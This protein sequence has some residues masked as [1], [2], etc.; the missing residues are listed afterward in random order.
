MKKIILII[1]LCCTTPLLYAQTDVIMQQVKTYIS[2][3]DYKTA[4]AFLEREAKKKNV[5]PETFELLGD[6]Y[7]ALNDRKK[8]AQYYERRIA[9]GGNNIPPDVFL[10]YGELLIHEGKYA[11]AKTHLRTY[12]NNA[13]DPDPLAETLMASCDTAMIWV[14]R[15]D[16]NKIF[17]VENLKRLNSKFHDWG[18]MYHDNGIMFI[19]DRPRSKVDD[20]QYYAVY[21]SNYRR[22]KNLG[23]PELFFTNMKKNIHLGP[24]AF[25]KNGKTIYY[26]QTNT[27][28]PY[29]DKTEDGT[30]WE[31]KLEIKIAKITTNKLSSIKSFKYNS[32]REYSI[33]H[34]C[35]SP[36]DSV[37]Y[38]VSDMPG[39]FGGTDIYYSVLERG[40]EWSA[41]INAGSMIN[42]TGNEMFPTMDSTGVLYFSSNGKAG[43]GGLDIF[44]AKG[45]KNRWV[46]TENM[47][48]PINSSGDDFYL[49]LSSDKSSGFFASNRPGGA[50]NDDI[51]TLTV[52]G[53]FPDFGYMKDPLAY[54]KKVR[55]SEEKARLERIATFTG[56]VT[57]GATHEGIDSVM[58]SF[59]NNA[60][61][62]QVICTTGNA[63]VFSITLDKKGNYTYSCIREGYVPTIGQS[64]AG[65]NALIQ[66]K[67]IHIEMT[68]VKIEEENVIADNVILDTEQG[69]GIEYRVQVMASKEYPNWDYLNKVKEAYPQ[70]KILYG[71]FPDAFTR[72]TVGQFKTAKE[73]TKLKNELRAIGYRDAF[74]VMFVNGKRKVVSYN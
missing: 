10:H 62:E 48:Y 55:L 65:N 23:A 41:P 45:G 43:L 57:D 73:A 28:I 40:D 33:G 64:L 52:N 66:A 71:S 67:G 31:N 36:N 14:A 24:V 74:V 2:N 68:P 16:S 3:F 5:R 50:G 20:D 72:F 60:T 29:R 19:S 44:R 58:I 15:R 27:D 61:K 7:R 12:Y 13:A 38:Y 69:K 63:G 18:A 53:P 46:A 59:V 32:P 1:I 39:G 25:T 49:I 42:T 11:A 17:T 51:Y 21:Q 47:Y 6:C 22:D 30:V 54:E 4:I 37:L 56:T 70:L 26:T 35:L 8:A 9:K 34:A